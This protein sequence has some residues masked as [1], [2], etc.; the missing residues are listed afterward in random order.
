MKVR[1]AIFSC[2]AVMSVYAQ[3]TEVTPKQ[4]YLCIVEKAAEVTSDK[5]A[6]FEASSG[7]YEKKFLVTPEAGVKEFGTE[8]GILEACNYDSTGRPLFCEAPGESWAGTFIM[9]ED[10]TFV[11]SGMAFLGD[12]EAKAF[13]WFIG[14]CSSI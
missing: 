5:D 11:L 13:H 12:Q 10:N 3:D 2:M 4:S 7:A 8:F 6:N 1:I 14:K 9:D